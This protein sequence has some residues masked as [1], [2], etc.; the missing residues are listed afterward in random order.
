MKET[1]I[2]PEI[3]T[4]VVDADAALGVCGSGG[5]SA[6]NDAGNVGGGAIILGLLSSACTCLSAK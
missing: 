3:R 5:S 1:Y 4:E 6:P 2:K